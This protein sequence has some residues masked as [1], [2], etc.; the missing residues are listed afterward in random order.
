MKTPTLLVLSLYTSG[1]N[2]NMI[3]ESKKA[4]LNDNKSLM[5]LLTTGLKIS[6]IVNPIMTARI[7]KIIANKWLGILR[8]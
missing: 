1:R 6:A 7:G 5:L 2:S 8:C 3:T 4:P